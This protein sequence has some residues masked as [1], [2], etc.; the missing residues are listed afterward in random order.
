MAKTIDVNQDGSVRDLSGE[1]RVLHVVYLLH[2]LAP[3][4]MWLLAALA[5]FI[6]M[7]KRDDV[8]GTNLDS[9][10]GWLAGAFWWA[11]LWIVISWAVFWLITV[12]T[13]GLGAI[14]MWMVPATAYVVLFVWYLYRVVRGWVRLNDGLAMPQPGALN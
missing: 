12:L 6:G 10:Y 2:A 13:L 8:R 9:H 14:V 11:L 3:F 1:R 7:L 4:T 5:V